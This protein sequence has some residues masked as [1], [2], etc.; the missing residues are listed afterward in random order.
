MSTPDLGEVILM[1]SA[2]IRDPVADHL[3]TPQNA[4]L[5]L[6]DY[7]PAQFATVR[8]M[9]PGLLLKKIV[10]TV[11]TAKSFGL[12]IAHSTIN[13]ASGRERPT[14]PGLEEGT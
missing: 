2:S 9:D 5:I 4:A 3:I 1:T 6:I 13:L 8:S 7:Q 11:K 14:V 10:S 12:P